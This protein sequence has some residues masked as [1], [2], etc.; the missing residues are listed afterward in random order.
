MI[1]NEWVCIKNLPKSINHKK[2]SGVNL[3]SHTH[4]FPGCYF[5]F[6]I[7]C[8]SIEIPNYISVLFIYE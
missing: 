5:H 8:T 4:S 3:V 7:V 2:I 1:F 6:V